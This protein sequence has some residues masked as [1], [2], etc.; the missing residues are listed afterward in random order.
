MHAALKWPA[1][2]WLGRI[3]YSWYLWQEL[4]VVVRQPS[5]GIVRTFPST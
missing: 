4:F 1:L 3:S 2:R 5:W